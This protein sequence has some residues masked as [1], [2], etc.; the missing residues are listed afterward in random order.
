MEQFLRGLQGNTGNNVFCLY[1]C[2]AGDSIKLLK[3]LMTAIIPSAVQTR[4]TPE[5]SCP[6]DLF[7]RLNFTMSDKNFNDDMTVY[8]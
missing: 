5:I 7:A 4:C 1:V 6:R 8:E 3:P 2:H